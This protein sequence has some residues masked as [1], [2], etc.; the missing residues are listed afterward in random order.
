MRLANC[1][2]CGTQG[3]TIENKFT[4]DGY[5]AFC[6]ECLQFGPTIEGPTRDDAIR[7]WNDLNEDVGGAM[8]TVEGK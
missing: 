8:K 3:K 1:H 2:K 7:E 5:F 4:G 6:P